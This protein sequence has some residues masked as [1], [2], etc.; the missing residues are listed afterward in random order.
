MSSL[1]N[2]AGFSH[3][4]DT[5]HLRPG[6]SIALRVVYGSFACT[7]ALSLVAVATIASC[8][9]ESASIARPAVDPSAPHLVDHDTSPPRPPLGASVRLNHQPR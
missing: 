5:P 2:T 3:T 9:P 8:V 4:R 7:A 6:I 1:P